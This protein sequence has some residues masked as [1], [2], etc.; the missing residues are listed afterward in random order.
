[1][2]QRKEVFEHG[3]GVDYA[4]QLRK[5]RKDIIEERMKT[6]EKPQ[7]AAKNPN[8]PEV[9]HA[10]IMERNVLEMITF[11]PQLELLEEV[12]EV[13]EHGF[14]V[15]YA[16]QLRKERKDIIEERMKEVSSLK[17]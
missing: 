16:R 12:K 15:D 10:F 9:V 1:M 14:G 4:R 5:E 8:A 3:F 6:Q 11:A 17:C 13:F 2:H 7:I